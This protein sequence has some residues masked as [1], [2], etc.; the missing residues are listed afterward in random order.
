MTEIIIHC[1]YTVNLLC[2]RVFK[3]MVNSFGGSE[4][5]TVCRILKKPTTL[6]DWAISQ[7]LRVSNV[8][9]SILISVPNLSKVHVLFAGTVHGKMPCC[10]SNILLTISAKTLKYRY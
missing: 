3:I 2:I 8:G 6:Q 7:C 10:Q 5:L 4:W 1:K 9:A